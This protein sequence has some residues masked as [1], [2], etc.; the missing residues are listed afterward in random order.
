MTAQHLPFRSADDENTAM[1]EIEEEIVDPIIKVKIT[2]KNG[3][4]FYF[5]EFSELI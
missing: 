4:S 2:K 3:L 1:E 5:L